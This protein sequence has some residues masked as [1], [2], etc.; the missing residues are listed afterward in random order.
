VHWHSERG[1]ALPM[2]LGMMLVVSIALITVLERSSSTERHSELS[3]ANQI[4]VAVAEAGLNQAQSVVAHA[5]SPTALPTSCASSPTV[6]AEG[7]TACYWGSFNSTTSVLTVTAVSSVPNPTGGAAVSHTV[8]AQFDVQAS[9]VPDNDVWNYV[10]SNAPG[11]TY[12]QNNV[13][14]SA[15]LYTKGDLCLKNNAAVTGAKV[16]VY[17]GIQIEDSGRVGASPSDASDPAVRS[18]FGCRIGSSGGFDAACSDLTYPV[19]RSSYS[20]SPPNMTKPPFDASKRST[21]KPG[22]LQP[23]TTSSGSV[24]SFT[25]TSVINLMPTASYTCQVWQ[26]GTLVG[27]LSW[28]NDAGDK[29]LTIK[30]TIWF[31]GELVMD[32]D[33]KGTY[34]GEATIYFA[35]KA[36][37]RNNTELCATS[38]CTTSGWDPNTQ[39]LALVTGAP[40]FPAFDLQ[41]F[42]KF[43]GAIYSVGGFRLQNNAV[44]HGPV[45]ADALDVQNNGLPSA[46]PTITSVLN[47][48]PQNPTS[49][50][51]VTPV[52]NSWRG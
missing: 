3:K 24:P 13:Q 34:S 37:I 49:T 16:D 41:N 2:A 52:P 18:R 45:I 12:Y 14:V 42:A 31:D 23:C 43:Q 29:R 33:N 20:N 1:I 40:D 26:S 7:G 25:T 4:A 22:P 10:F 15:P 35:K 30:G 48:M 44:M 17:G 9:T 50:Y 11:C 6:T 19:Y 27:E 47:G 32:N 51:T 21:A 46:W 8:T 38:G 36:A 5:G 39:M 28:D